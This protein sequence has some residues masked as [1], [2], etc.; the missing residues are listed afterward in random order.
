MDCK[1]TRCKWLGEYRLH[2]S[3]FFPNKW[4]SPLNMPLIPWTSWCFGLSSVRLSE[5]SSI[6]GP[7]GAIAALLNISYLPSGKR[8]HF[9]ME[10]STLLLLGNLTISMA[11]FN[12][13]V[14]GHYQRVSNSAMFR[15]GAWTLRHGPGPVLRLP[16]SQK[17]AQSV[18][19]LERP[20]FS[21]VV[22]SSIVKLLNIAEF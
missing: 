7:I 10:R 8:L 9:A 2:V 16:S 12:S 17:A 14:V 13:Y 5:S 20:C 11:L 4:I 18:D 1:S 22:I 19:Q 6:G 3:L 15:R 21:W